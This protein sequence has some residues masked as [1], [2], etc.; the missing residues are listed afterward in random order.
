MSIKEDFNYLAVDPFS[1]HAYFDDM[2]IKTD[3]LADPRKDMVLPIMLEEQVFV[4][5]QMVEPVR[6]LVNAKGG[7]FRI[8]D[9]GTGSGVF[10][11]Y[12]DRA[13]REDETKD[14]YTIQAIDISQRAL[15]RAIS[16]TNANNCL[17]IEIPIEAEKYLYSTVPE[18]SLDL[19]L[20]N[21]PFNPTCPDIQD[22]ASVCASSDE[23]GLPILRDW[24]GYITQ[25]LRSSG[26]LIGCHMTPVDTDGKL[27]AL[28][29]M[30]KAFG[31]KS[32]IRYC[33]IL[34]EV[35]PSKNFLEKQYCDYLTNQELA[36]RIVPWIDTMSDQ[37]PSFAFIYFEAQ[38]DGGS[39]DI[40]ENIEP[41]FSGYNRSWEDRIQ[42]HRFFVNNFKDRL[43][44]KSENNLGD[45]N[46]LE[47]EQIIRDSHKTDDLSNHPQILSDL[48][49]P[50]SKYLESKI[51]TFDLINENWIQKNIKWMFF[52]CGIFCPFDLIDDPWEL[53][54]FGMLKWLTNSKQMRDEPQEIFKSWQQIVQQSVRKKQSISFSKK[55]A[56]SKSREKWSPNIGDRED[57]LVT[58]SSDSAIKKAIDNLVIDE[59]DLNVDLLGNIDD[60]TYFKI[61]RTTKLPFQEN[62][63]KQSIDVPETQVI[64][65]AL[66]HKILHEKQ[67]INSETFFISVPLYVKSPENKSSEDK[68]VLP[69]TIAGCIFLFGE[70]NGSY[71]EDSWEKLKDI[72]IG[73]R[74]DFSAIASGY[75]YFRSHTKAYSR[76]LNKIYHELDQHRSLL[77]PQSVPEIID[78]IRFMFDLLFSSRLDDV[79]SSAIVDSFVGESLET[80]VNQLIEYSIKNHLIQSRKISMKIA[81]DRHLLEKEITEFKINYFDSKFVLTYSEEIRNKIATITGL[82][83]FCS[84]FILAINNILGKYKGKVTIFFDTE[85]RIINDIAVEVQKKVGSYGTLPILR[86]ILKSTERESFAFENLE[87][88][89]L[90]RLPEYVQWKD[91]IDTE[92]WITKFPLIVQ[93]E[94]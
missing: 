35:Y 61:L 54:D 78:V 14:K 40:L 91:N 81:A 71:Q 83:R 3:T 87:L 39:G 76:I 52:E 70:F 49:K 90:Q 50:V 66:L 41:V 22:F 85:V 25:H 92:L 55:F 6:R 29:E 36:E 62:V 51:N 73:M 79:S 94:K 68:D 86:D 72:A 30:K 4:C 21:P 43:E 7:D 17:K 89:V 27:V 2:Y 18:N 19:I 45:V 11:I 38:M 65:H 56:R 59:A 37:Y 32:K 10:S 20:I 75:A 9:V 93:L 16:N 67:V 84:M 80:I 31:N 8:L 58:L 5:K 60:R 13:L 1:D 48:A 82:Q 47:V 33:R 63:L 26:M 57:F 24:L 28:E 23:F 12:L 74:D 53:L 42:R 69:Y 15:D 88:A 77:R 34:P 44:F 46:I 64:S